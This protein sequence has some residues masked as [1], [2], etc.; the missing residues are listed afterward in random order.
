MRMRIF[1]CLFCLCWRREKGDYMKLPVIRLLKHGINI[2]QDN[3]IL[4]DFCR[5]VYKYLQNFLKNNTLHKFIHCYPKN[6]VYSAVNGVVEVEYGISPAGKTG[7]KFL[8]CLDFGGTILGL[9]ATGVR[10]AA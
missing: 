8:R 9:V 10:I 3:N 1:V 2:Q 4:I 7:R 6:G 5:R